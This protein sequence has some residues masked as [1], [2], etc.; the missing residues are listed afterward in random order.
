MGAGR[1]RKRACGGPWPGG[2]LRVKGEGEGVGVGVGVGVVVRLPA[3]REGKIFDKI[4]TRVLRS[5]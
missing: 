2:D 1:V 5:G 4:A 3:V